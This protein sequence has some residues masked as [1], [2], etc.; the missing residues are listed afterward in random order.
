MPIQH[1]HSSPKQTNFFWFRFF[2]VSLDF[3]KYFGFGCCSCHY[4]PVLFVYICL[5]YIFSVSPFEDFS[6]SVCVSVLLVRSLDI[7]KKDTFS[8]L[9]IF[10]MDCHNCSSFN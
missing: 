10:G 7:L 3:F 4:L 2:L 8:L 1:G 6:V 5:I 9:W